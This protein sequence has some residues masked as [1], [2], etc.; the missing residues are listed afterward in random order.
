M[1]LDLHDFSRW[2]PSAILNLFCACFD[3]T[4]GAFGGLCTVPNLV[5][6]GAV[7]SIMQVLIFCALGLKMLIHTPKIGV[8]GDLTSKMGNSTRGRAQII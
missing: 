8:F 7:V 6:I 3:N 4:G 5:G 2:R 1:W